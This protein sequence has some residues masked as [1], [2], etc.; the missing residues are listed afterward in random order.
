MNYGSDVRLASSGLHQVQRL[1]FSF[2]FK[3]VSGTR[4]PALSTAGGHFLYDDRSDLPTCGSSCSLPGVA[5]PQAK[6]HRAEV[7]LPLLLFSCTQRREC[8]QT[9]TGTPP[10]H[11]SEGRLGRFSSLL[12]FSVTTLHGECVQ[13]TAEEAL[14]SQQYSPFFPPHGSCAGWFVSL[15]L[16]HSPS[17]HALGD[18]L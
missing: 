12:P 4:R 14:L 17:A 10:G 8:R 13:Q 3:P 9:C 7:Q 2:T 15:A 18:L 16:R 11:P 5:L 6:A 1:L